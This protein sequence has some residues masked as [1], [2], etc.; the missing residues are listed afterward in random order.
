[1]SRWIPRLL[2][3]GVLTLALTTL[4]VTADSGGQAT[5]AQIRAAT[6]RFH[7][8][9]VAWNDAGYSTTLG[10][11][12]FDLPGTGGMGLHYINTSLIGGRDPLQPAAMVYEVR[13][14]GS[15]QLGAV[16]WI[17]GDASGTNRPAPLLGHDWTYV[18]SLQVWVLHA[19]IWQP[20]PDGMFANYNPAV[21][22]CPAS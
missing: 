14:D 17:I 7:D 20:N 21:P 10:L 8:P 22:L 4:P 1:M 11:P 5:I 18:S 2:V 6:A 19:W 16:E 12:C 15:L 3:G 9:S 13:S